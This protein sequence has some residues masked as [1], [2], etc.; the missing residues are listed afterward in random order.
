[1]ISNN[2]FN[3]DI[4]SGKILYIDE[5]KT[6]GESATFEAPINKFGTGDGSN[7]VSIRSGKVGIGI[8]DPQYPLHVNGEGH[9]GGNFTISGSSTT[10]G[11]NYTVSNS[12]VGGN[13]E[14][15][16]SATIQGDN[17]TES[18]SF[19]GGNLTTSGNATIEGDLTVEGDSFVVEATT[20]KIEDKNIELGVTSTGTATD[21]TAHGGGITLHGDTN[22]TILFNNDTDSWD[23]SE[24]IGV[25]N[26]KHIFTD[27]VK[28]RD[29]DGLKLEDSGGAG[30]YIKNGGNVGI[31]DIT[32][33]NANPT[34]PSAKLEILTQVNGSGY[35]LRVNSNSRGYG[36]GYIWFGDNANPDFYVDTAGQIGMGTSSP[37]SK[38]HVKGGNAK[39]ESDGPRLTLYDSNGGDT[40]EQNGFITWWGDGA[41]RGWVGFGSTLTK[42]FGVHNAIGD[43]VLSSGTTGKIRIQGDGKV[44][45][46]T[47]NPTEILDVNGRIFLR[48]NTTPAQTANRLYSVSGVLYWN[49]TT[50]ENQPASNAAITL[51]AGSGMT[52]GGSFDL[53]QSSAETITITHANTGDQASISASGRTYVRGVNLDQFGHVTS[54]SMGTETMVNTNTTYQ[55]GSGLFLTGTSFVISNNLVGK[56]HSIGNSNSDKIVTAPNSISFTTGN[57]EKAKLQSTGDLHVDGDVLAFSSTVSDEKLK[58]NINT[59]NNGLEKVKKLR[60]VSYKWRKG[61]R[62]G[63]DD[64]GVVAQEVEKVIPEIVRETIP[65]VGD[66]CENTESYKA[67]DYEKITA[68]LIEAVKD[69]SAEVDELKKKLS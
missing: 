63:Q 29:S 18:N 38:L 15:S 25:A 11:D 10:E 2:I 46:A 37:N 44:G 9:L 16:G 5:V 24:H 58:E 6:T 30:L 68:L 62:K 27:K 33:F 31:G 3:S 48:D 43:L 55:A 39:I 12:F 59:I 1:M 47:P 21:L 4:F 35:G 14:T 41:E 22:K 67:V 53:D 19:V 34:A 56:V 17:Y 49:G 61:S 20:V 40:V 36:E 69:L 42:D 28:A 50:L 64:I 57:A 23:F 65:C 54:L 52:G 13:F 26:G 45:I 51:A 66:F 60:G 7:I 32:S 8:T